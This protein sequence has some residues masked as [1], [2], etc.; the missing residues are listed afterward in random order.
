VGLGPTLA[1]LLA[2]ILSGVVANYTSWRNVYWMGFGFQLCVLAALYL[3]MPD[4][5]A[6]NATP[7]RQIAKSYPS[8]LASILALYVQHPVLVQA[9]LLA[10]ISFTTLTAY[11]TTLTFLLAS[12]PYNYNSAAIG[13]FGLIGAATLILGP[14]FAKFVITPLRVPLYSAALGNTLSLLGI[15]LG[16]FLGTKHVAGPVIE[17]ILLDAGLVVVFIAN[18]LSIEGVAPGKANRVNTAFMVVMYLGQLAGTKAGND[19]YEFNGGWIPAGLWAVG[20]SVAGYVVILARGPN[21]Q[22]ATWVGWHGGWRY[23]PAVAASGEGVGSSDD[24]EKGS[25][26][27]GTEADDVESLRSSK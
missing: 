21:V 26:N 16:T 19:I 18:R 17:A 15:L 11:W 22:R 7:A 25:K 1:I 23:R 9:C 20:I 27:A 5:A 3:S 12:P 6:I 2:R 14:I 8:V 10:F 13:L 24:E 4:Y